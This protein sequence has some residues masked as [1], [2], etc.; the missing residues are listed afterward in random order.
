MSSACLHPQPGPRLIR[1]WEEVMGQG[2]PRIL[3]LQNL[4]VSPMGG[5]SQKME[6]QRRAC[7]GSITLAE[8]ATALPSGCSA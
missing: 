2:H 3:D 5:A 7:P 6:P 8:D 4:S 1:D